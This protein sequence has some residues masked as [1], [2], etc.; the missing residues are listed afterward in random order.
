MAEIREAIGAGYFEAY[1]KEFYAQKD[2][3][4]T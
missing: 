2:G 3:G 1:A 4:T